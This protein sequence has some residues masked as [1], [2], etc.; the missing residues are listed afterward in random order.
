MIDGDRALSRRAL[1]EQ[2]SLGLDGFIA[3]IEGARN[4]LNLQLSELSSKVSEFHLS[5]TRE[6][7]N[8]EQMVAAQPRARQAG[9]RGERDAVRGRQAVRPGVEEGA[10]RAQPQ[11]RRPRRAAPEGARLFHQQQARP[12]GVRQQDQAPEGGGGRGGAVCVQHGEGDLRAPAERDLAPGQGGRAAQ[13]PQVL[14]LR[15]GARALRG[16]RP[17]PLAGRVRA[18]GAR[19]G[20]STRARRGTTRSSTTATGTSRR[21]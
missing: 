20:P 2:D 8:L 6:K 11:V 3:E 17:A 21:G 14:R 7:A 19:R 5:Y 18:R 9:P 15:R 12:R 10:H 16:E 13:Q 4:D 1:A